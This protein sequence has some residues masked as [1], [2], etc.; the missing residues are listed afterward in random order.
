MPLLNSYQA[1]FGGVLVVIIFGI[2]VEKHYVSRSTIFS[3]ILSLILL[4][5]SIRIP[6]VLL[7]ALII[8]LALGSL[9]MKLKVKFLSPAFGARAYGSLALVL[10]LHSK[11]FIPGL[12]GRGLREIILILCILWILLMA[13]VHFIGNLYMKWRW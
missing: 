8:Y 11:A 12:E 9:V 5:A 3:N 13:V 10:L 7:L 1:A 4:M 6:S 2:I